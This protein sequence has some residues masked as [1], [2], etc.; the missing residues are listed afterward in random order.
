M[1]GQTASTMSGTDRAK[2]THRWLGGRDRW[3]NQRG[4]DRGT[5]ALGGWTDGRKDKTGH[6]GRAD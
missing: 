4:T 3:T 2:G 1:G 6:E 5:D